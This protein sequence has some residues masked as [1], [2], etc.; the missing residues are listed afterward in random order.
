MG[1]GLMIAGLCA[2]KNIG[3][4]RWG[5]SRCDGLRLGTST[6]LPLSRSTG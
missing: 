2:G 3:I 6:L 4:G 5:W 1:E